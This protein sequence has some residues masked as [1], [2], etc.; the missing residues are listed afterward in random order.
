MQGMEK[1]AKKLVLMKEKDEDYRDVSAADMGGHR[2][3]KVNIGKAISNKLY[4]F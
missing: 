2:C 1:W 4:R 3:M